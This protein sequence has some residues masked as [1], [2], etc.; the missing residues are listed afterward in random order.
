MRLSVAVCTWN[1]AGLLR[2]ALEQMTRLVVPEDVEWE[3]L[4][5]NNNCT[6]ATDEVVAAFAR[7]LPIQGLREP[8]P[9]LSHAR[10]RAVQAAAGDYILWTDDDVL[11][12][13]SW[14]RAYRDAFARWPRAAVFGGPIRPLFEG[15]PPAW[16]ERTLPRIGGVFAVR[17]L[18]TEPVPLGVAGDR[19]PYGANYAVR[20]IEQ[21]RFLYRADLGRR[22]GGV[23]LGGEE[24]ELLSEILGSGATGWWVPAARVRHIIPPERQTI[25]YVRAYCAGYGQYLR[26]KAGGAGPPGRWALLRRAAA[27]ELRYRV[28][29]VIARP[30]RWVEDLILA[31][32]T[33]GQLR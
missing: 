13:E 1:R 18:G 30:E 6:D 32:E 33:W 20:M 4:V 9:G 15:S 11:V 2:R 10:S 21:R 16:L 31:S 14:L 17:D 3:L 7:S 5:V 23:L 12:D 22:P 27:A 25:R 28:G 29:R 8:Q 24:R 19:L 26:W